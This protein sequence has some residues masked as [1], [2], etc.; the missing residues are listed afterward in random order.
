MRRS[1]LSTLL[2]CVAF[3]F[4]LIADARAAVGPAASGQQCTPASDLRGS[5]VKEPAA[6]DVA[7]VAQLCLNDFSQDSLAHIPFS[8]GAGA[9]VSDATVTRDESLPPLSAL[10]TGEATSIDIRSRN[11]NWAHLFS[12]AFWRAPAITEQGEIQAIDRGQAR[13]AV[14]A[15]L[16][17]F[18]VVMPRFL[19]R[20]KGTEFLVDYEPD[21]VA[22][23]S[24]S[25]GRVAITRIVAVRLVEE[26]RTVDG[27][28]Q[29]D[30]IVA[31]GR[32]SIE[33]RLPLP[34]FRQFKNLHEAEQAFSDRLQAA[35]QSGD[36]QTIDDALNNLQLI[37]GRPF[38]G[39]APVH[40]GVQPA[41]IAGALSAAAGGAA[42]AVVITSNAATA[43]APVPVTGGVTLQSKTAASTPSP[44]PAAIPRAAPTE[45]RPAPA[46][47]P[48]APPRP[49]ATLAS[50]APAVAA[51]PTPSPQRP[52]PLSEPLPSSAHHIAGAKPW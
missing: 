45:L 49:T 2:L 43:A 8:G 51:R 37:T 40:G 38:A 10:G 9:P 32:S 15:S 36:P 5:T 23:F 17:Y 25:E 33:Y 7:T 3:A 42:A 28:R 21:K 27:I 50:A 30:E 13:F 41:A 18:A 48:V 4:A 44:A 46:A 52:A 6:G 39:F 1:A 22:S 12:G 19:A 29:T 11:G 31:D 14:A 20:V 16:G 24:V 34:L 26:N 47:A 35:V